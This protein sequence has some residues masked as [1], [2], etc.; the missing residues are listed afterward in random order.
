MTR[1]DKFTWVPSN[2]LLEW[3]YMGTL[4]RPT[5]MRLHRCP[6]MTTRT[7]LHGHPHNLNEGTRESWENELHKHTQSPPQVITYH[8]WYGLVCL[9]TPSHWTTWLN[10]FTWTPS[11]D[12]PEQVY[13]GALEWPAQTSLHELPQMTSLNEFRRTPSND[14]PKWVYVDTLKQPTWMRLHGSHMTKTKAWGRSEQTSCMNVHKAHP[15]SQLSIFD[16]GWCAWVCP[17]IK[18]PE[19]MSLQEHPKMTCLN[20]FTQAPSN[21]LL[22]WVYTNALKWL[23]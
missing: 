1:P 12:P 21:D 3:V 11:N 17:H 22:E 8:F 19:W 16:M 14:P 18:Q 13:T 9:G 2:D 6:K 7:S 4:E 5:R 10:E 20:E 23:G 15:R